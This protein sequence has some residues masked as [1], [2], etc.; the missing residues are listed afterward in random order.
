M[1]SVIFG[2]A[3][4]CLCREPSW[5]Y[6]RGGCLGLPHSQFWY[7][8]NMVKHRFPVPV[9][10]ASKTR[11]C[12]NLRSWNTRGQ[13]FSWL[14][15]TQVMSSCNGKCSKMFMVSS[16][17]TGRMWKNNEECRSS[18]VIPSSWSLL[19]FDYLRHEK[20]WHVR[21]PEPRIPLCPQPPNIV[22]SHVC[23]CPHRESW[24]VL[25]IDQNTCV[26]KM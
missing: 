10:F 11:L 25:S 18:M 20:R 13:S 22:L 12:S 21:R 15:T 8:S 23:A 17:C 5:F 1:A 4:L 7:G 6:Y 9:L 19:L 3:G 24:T 26:H 14:T 16:L 2:R